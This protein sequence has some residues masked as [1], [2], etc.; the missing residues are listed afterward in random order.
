MGP[1]RRVSGLLLQ[2][3]YPG[4]SPSSGGLATGALAGAINGWLIAYVGLSPFVVTL[5]CCPSRARSPW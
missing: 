4:G 1:R 3:E 2:G 5:G